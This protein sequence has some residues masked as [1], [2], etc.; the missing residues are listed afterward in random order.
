MP[1]SKEEIMATELD[2]SI[3]KVKERLAKLRE[4]L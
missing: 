1:V 4:Y 2:M 3:D